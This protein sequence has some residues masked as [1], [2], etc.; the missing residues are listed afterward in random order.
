MNCVRAANRITLER[1]VEVKDA[2]QGKISSLLCLVIEGEEV[3]FSW[4]KDG[5]VITPSERISLYSDGT[6]SKLTFRQTQV[7][8]SGNYT[9]V[10]RNEAST[11]RMVVKFSVE[12]RRTLANRC[13]VF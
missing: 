10:A 6:G 13:T 1:S 5:H 9:C 7:S 12:G 8:D 2:I 3:S 4:L 11:A